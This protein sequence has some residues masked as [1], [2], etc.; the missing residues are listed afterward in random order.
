MVAT[1]FVAFNCYIGYWYSRLIRHRFVEAVK[2]MYKESHVVD[3]IRI[4]PTSGTSGSETATGQQD[5]EIWLE[6]HED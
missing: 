6:K 2:S 5:M 3:G 4:A 1:A